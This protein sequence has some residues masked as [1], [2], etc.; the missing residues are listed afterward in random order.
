MF[1]EWT[2]MSLREISDRIVALSS[3]PAMPVRQPVAPLPPRDQGLRPAH[4]QPPPA[5]WSPH[6]SRN[7]QPR[8]PR[9]RRHHRR[10]RREAKEAGSRREATRAAE[11]PCGYTDVCVSEESPRNHKLFSFFMSIWLFCSGHSFKYVKPKAPLHSIMCFFYRREKILR[12]LPLKS[13]FCCSV[14]AD[15]FLKCFCFYLWPFDVTVNWTKKTTDVAT[16]YFFMKG[17]ENGNKPFLYCYL[18]F[19]AVL[20]YHYMPNVHLYIYIINCNNRYLCWFSQLLFSE[21]SIKSLKSCPSWHRS[22]FVGPL[23]FHLGKNYSSN[24]QDSL[25]NK[26]LLQGNLKFWENCP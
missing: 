1:P 3:V 18:V 4:L 17:P 24:V 15:S 19:L 7:L 20:F 5:T 14:K 26:L 23:D 2:D 6:D 25:E 16:S 13:T 10:R 11:G 22:H 21:V 12:T 8:G 9:A